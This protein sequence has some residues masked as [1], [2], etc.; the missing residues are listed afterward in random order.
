MA[1]GDGGHIYLWGNDSS[2][3]D[4]WVND[5]PISAFTL[6]AATRAKLT[7]YTGDYLKVFTTITTTTNGAIIRGQICDYDSVAVTGQREVRI[8]FHDG[9]FVAMN[10]TLSSVATGTTLAT[11]V[12]TN[13]HWLWTDANGAFQAIF[14]FGEA[15]NNAKGYVNCGP[16]Y[17]QTTTISVA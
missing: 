2:T 8:N 9:S 3:L 4:L 16:F 15:K 1:T 10:S 14:A 5:D 12:K 7:H 13:A 6:A 11:T 17:G